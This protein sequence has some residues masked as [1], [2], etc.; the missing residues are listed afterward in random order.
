MPTGCGAPLLI[1]C[2]ARPELLD[3]RPGGAEAGC[4]SAA[5]E[6]EPLAEEES[7]E[8]VDALLAATTSS[9]CRCRELLDVTEGNPLFVEET[10]RMLAEGGERLASACPTRCR[11]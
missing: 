6:L 4:G 10:I 8:L 11:R 7:E 3:V 1:L 5:I 2:L 9:R